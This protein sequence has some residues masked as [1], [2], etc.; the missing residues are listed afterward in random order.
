MSFA[1]AVLRHATCPLIV[2]DWCQSQSIYQVTSV[3]SLHLFTLRRRV[4]SRRQLDAIASGTNV[5]VVE[6]LTLQAVTL[7]LTACRNLVGRASGEALCLFRGHRA[8]MSTTSY[9]HVEYG[10]ADTFQPFANDITETPRRLCGPALSIRVSK[11]VGLACPP[12]HLSMPNR[13][14]PASRHLVRDTVRSL[15]G[16]QHSAA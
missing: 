11:S 10:Y 8:R 12:R 7:P 15:Y 9:A 4:A 16:S 1:R 2:L 14:V 5:V 6:A 3:A 13:A